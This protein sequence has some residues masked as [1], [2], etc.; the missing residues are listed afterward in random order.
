MQ[1]ETLP[2]TR[3]EGFP[4]TAI[5]GDLLLGFMDAV[6]VLRAKGPPVQRWLSERVLVRSGNICWYCGLPAQNV[7][8]L[9][10]AALG[11][12][13]KEENLV[14]CCPSCR[15]LFLDRDPSALA[16]AT[17]EPIAEGKRAQRAI[18]LAGAAQHAVPSRARASVA[19]C[20]AWLAETR[21]P[22]PRVP[23]AVLCGSEETLLTPI[24]ATPGMAWATLAMSARQAGALPVAMLPSVFVL[25]TDA[26]A[27]L[28]WLLI[29]R[30]ALL[31]RV[32]LTGF[33]SAGEKLDAKTG[34]PFGYGQ[35]DR[36]FHGAQ[37]TARGREAKARTGFGAHME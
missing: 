27:G 11:G 17:G 2:S 13:K 1:H 32:E 26:W 20:T 10:S 12:H 23:V 24:A 33:E 14:A 16:W 29:E 28:A 3:I 19:T 35:W 21:W 22:F 6:V 7:T 9:F 25:P 37:Q 30:G 8:P 36:L 15:V 4:M 31:R 5:S 34:K 18:A